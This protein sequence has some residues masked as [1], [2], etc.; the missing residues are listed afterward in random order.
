[1]ASLLRVLF[2]LA[3]VGASFAAL[4]RG[5]AEVHKDFPGKCYVASLG[6]GFNPGSS[7]PMSEKCA[8]RTCYEEDGELY[9][10]EASCGVAIPSAN[11]RVVEE[12]TLPHPYCCPRLDCN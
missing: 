1:M 9:F 3:V 5:K 10:E 7:W 4:F 6:T 11:C 8:K 2:F 12:T